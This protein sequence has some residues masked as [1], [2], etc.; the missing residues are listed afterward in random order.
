L[1][2]IGVRGG[3]RIQQ[4]DYTG[5]ATESDQY[6]IESVVESNIFLV[7]GFQADVMPND[8]GERVT[9]QDMA[10]LLAYLKTFE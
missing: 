2:G 1:P 10:N 9:L 5:N 8:F 3:I 7:E 6:L 4:D